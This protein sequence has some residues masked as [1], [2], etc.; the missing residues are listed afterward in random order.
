MAACKRTRLCNC[1]S[2]GEQLAMWWCK[3]L[4]GRTWQSHSKSGGVRHA[5][6]SG[7]VETLPKYPRTQIWWD[8]IGFWWDLVCKVWA[9][10]LCS[11]WITVLWSSWST[12]QL[13]IEKHT[14]FTGSLGTKELMPEAS[15]VI[16]KG[17]RWFKCNACT[18]TFGSHIDSFFRGL[19]EPQTSLECLLWGAS[20]CGPSWHSEEAPLRWTRS[21]QS[22]RSC[23][24]W[25][26]VTKLQNFLL[27]HCWLFITFVLQ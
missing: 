2:S 23:N 20:R 21:I 1:R 22:T 16:I 3:S 10:D 7:D 11:H 6:A 9:Y 8:L 15:W 14:F 26:G 27:I 5:W 24:S 17:L 12:R 19:P 18:C 25:K 4:A 13:H